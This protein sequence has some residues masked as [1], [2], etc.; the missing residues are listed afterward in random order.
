M[1]AWPEPLVTGSGQPFGT[2]F[3]ARVC[4]P[5]SESH[6]MQWRHRFMLAAPNSDG[7]AS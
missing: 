6:L 2:S 1:K 5:L 7:D 3:G 4:S